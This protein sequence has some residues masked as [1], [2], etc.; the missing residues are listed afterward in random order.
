MDR[1]WTEKQLSLENGKA[2]QGDNVVFQCGRT[3]LEEGMLT[4]VLRQDNYKN[5]TPIAHILREATT[6][7]QEFYEKVKGAFAVYR[8]AKKYLE[9]NR[10]ARSLVR[11]HVQNTHLALA[12][13]F[14][15]KLVINFLYTLSS[16]SCAFYHAFFCDFNF[17]HNPDE[18]FILIQLD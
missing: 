2:K 4:D 12:F 8:N 3:F 16:W 14:A 9:L 18:T 5:I 17:F 10:G 6:H 11:T 7:L 1:N 15:N 13:C